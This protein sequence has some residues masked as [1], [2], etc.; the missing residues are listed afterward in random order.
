VRAFIEH[1]LDDLSMRKTAIQ[2]GQSVA[3]NSRSCMQLLSLLDAFLVAC[4]KMQSAEDAHAAAVAAHAGHAAPVP[5]SVSFH[6]HV[7]ASHPAYFDSLFDLLSLSGEVASR[8]WALLV[9][10]PTNADMSNAIAQLPEKVAAA[11]SA[12]GAA[13]AD[14]RGAPAV[15]SAA[16]P[17]VD[18]STLLSPHST[19]KLLYQCQLVHAHLQSS[20]E[21]DEQQRAVEAWSCVF[22]EQGGFAY[23]SG[24]LLSQ[25]L[26][27]M[28]NDDALSQ[29]CL[30]SLI[31]L[32]DMF[33]QYPVD[34]TAARLTD[35][36]VRYEQII[37][38]MLDILQRAVSA[39][40]VD[41]DTTPNGQPAG[42]NAEPQRYRGLVLYAAQLLAH[43]L[44]RLPAN[45]PL[46]AVPVS[47]PGWDPI[48]ENGLLNHSSLVLRDLLAQGIALLCGDGEAGNEAAA[49]TAQQQLT[50]FFLPKLL[51]L[52]QRIDTRSVLCQQYFEATSRVLRAAVVHGVAFD[53]AALAS[54]II[55]QLQRHPI[56]E[57]RATD[58]DHVLAGYLQ[59][60]S[61]LLRQQ[62]QLKL[63]CQPLVKFV[64]DALF[65][66]PVAQDDSG[67]DGPSSTAT[68]GLPPPLC[69]SAG[70]RRF[71]FL[72]L[73]CLVHECASNLLQLC[74]LLLPLHATTHS[75]GTQPDEWD[76]QS[77]S[78]DKSEC[79]LVGLR[80]LGATYDTRAGTGTEAKQ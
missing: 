28:V 79:G 69:K 75:G 76:F 44:S 63:Q 68:G 77:S 60:L 54:H 52:L 50:A 64:F 1:C 71:A 66:L 39:T 72:L 30:A 59:L 40:H 35:A 31:R 56:L 16:S 22:L 18:W 70:S 78:D 4:D 15:A 8:V 42:N 38:A 29:Q 45:S 57:A 9:K 65:T 33:M 37:P 21:S 32:V 13:T 73:R 43:C 49:R 2:S 25:P 11:Q 41:R 24:L 47:F 48:L 80:N 6:R 58:E 3:D 10:L 34:S 17:L 53:Y 5:S 46:L 62:P 12:A 67:S 55:A 7:L 20:S 61:L 19:I 14:D 26:S 74:Q 27:R 51:N 36:V 23:V